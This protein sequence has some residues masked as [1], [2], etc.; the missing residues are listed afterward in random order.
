MTPNMPQYRM[1]ICTY[2]QAYIHTYPECSSLFEAIL[3]GLLLAV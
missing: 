1:N 3:P 2:I